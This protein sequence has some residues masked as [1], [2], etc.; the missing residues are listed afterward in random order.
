MDGNSKQCTNSQNEQIEM[1]YRG[2]GRYYTDIIRTMSDKLFNWAFTLNTGGLTA[3]ITF[4]AASIHWKACSYQD[5]SPFLIFIRLFGLGILSIVI[6]SFLEHKR[7]SKK[8][9]LLDRYYEN[10]TTVDEFMKNIPPKTN[11]YDT[12]APLLMYISYILFFSGLI[13]SI[14]TLIHKA[15]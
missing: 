9:K 5:I 11:C 1:I 4:I 3:T 12:F 2:H 10:A 7:F 14:F 15:R 13:V 6:S 8:G